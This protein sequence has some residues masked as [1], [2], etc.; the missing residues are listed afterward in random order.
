MIF[1]TP[2]FLFIF[3]P[4][5]WL[6]FWLLSFSGKQHLLLGWLGLASFVFYSVWDITLLPLLLGSIAVNYWLAGYV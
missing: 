2:E 4:T 3:L 1:S 6:I 5:V